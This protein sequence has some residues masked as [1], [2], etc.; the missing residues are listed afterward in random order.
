MRWSDLNLRTLHRNGQFE[1]YWENF[2]AAGLRSINFHVAHRRFPENCT[3]P[4]K[5][6]IV[7]FHA[8]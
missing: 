6:D 2:A 1:Q 3:K 4:K 5:E 7:L 8:A